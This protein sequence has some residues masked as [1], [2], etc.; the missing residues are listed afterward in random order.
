MNQ[1]DIRDQRLRYQIINTVI[2]VLVVLVA[3]VAIVFVRK[4]R[5]VRKSK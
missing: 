3:G 1:M 4:R 5:N 2:P